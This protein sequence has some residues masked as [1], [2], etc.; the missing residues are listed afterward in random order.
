MPPKGVAKP[1][2]RGAQPG[3]AAVEGLMLE[4]DDDHCSGPAKA[5]ED[6]S[7]IGAPRQQIVRTS[8]YRVK[9]T[10]VCGPDSAFQRV[11]RV[12]R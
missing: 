4:L 8:C 7:K 10:C 12:F 11:S 5:L 9:S 1:S 6:A 3:V 2:A